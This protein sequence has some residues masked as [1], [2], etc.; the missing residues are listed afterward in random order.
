MH[1]RCF[2]CSQNLL[3]R[4][5]PGSIGNS[6]RGFPLTYR[7]KTGVVFCLHRIYSYT[8]E[9]LDLGEKRLHAERNTFGDIQNRRI[10]RLKPLLFPLS[11]P[12][13]LTLFNNFKWYPMFIFP[14]VTLHSLHWIESRIPIKSWASTISWTSNV[15]Q[16]KFA[17]RRTLA[18]F[19]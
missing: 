15:L 3:P 1:R 11:L 4:R 7:K 5:F 16:T 6:E 2:G 13:F 10:F 18:I 9:V 8:P 17:L 19:K 12:H 14:L